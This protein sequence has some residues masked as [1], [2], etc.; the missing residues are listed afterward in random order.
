MSCKASKFNYIFN[1]EDGTALAFNATTSGLAKLVPEKAKIVHQILADPNGY[2]FDTAEKKDIKEKLLQGRFLVEAKEDEIGRLKVRNRLDRFSS[3]SFGLTIA[4]TLACNFRCKYCYE[5]AKP[6]VMKPAVEKAMVAMVKNRM[7]TAKM[8]SITWFGGEP[9]LALK[10]IGRLT[11]R[12]KAICKKNKAQYIASIVTNGYLWDRPTARKLKRWGV[13]N[14]QITLDGPKDIHDQRRPLAGG[15]GSYE[16]IMQNISQT[17]DIIPI[18]VRVN[19]D[20]TNAD[21]VLE[22]MDDIKKRGLQEK[23]KVYFAQVETYT[24]ACTNISGS[25]YSSQE[26][27]ALEVGLYRQ[28]IAKGFGITRYPRPILGGYCTADRVSALVVAPNGLLFKCWNQISG[29]RSEAVGDLLDKT[30]DPEHQANNE[31]WLAWDP[32]EKKECV[33]C[34]IL[35]LCMGGCPYNAKRFTKSQDKGHCASWKYH[36]QDMLNLTYL[37][38]PSSSSAKK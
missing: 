8:L 1:A 37:G 30:M 27:S 13:N 7:Q 25:C 28:A 23:V 11:G 34:S 24:D 21:R 14:V 38:Q 9:L 12:F 19:T 22:L 15:R 4:P 6:G 32:F 26:Y 5:T 36:L 35:P 33:D 18:N 2:K 17:H 16:R 20:K 31:E 3:Q 10:T 29:E